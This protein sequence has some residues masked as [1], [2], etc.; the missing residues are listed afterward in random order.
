M[1]V[2]ADVQTVAVDV[3][4]LDE[5][6]DQLGLL[7]FRSVSHLFGTVCSAEFFVVAVA[8]RPIVVSWDFD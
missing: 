8:D 7:C 2:E 5:R 4:A 1:Q 6:G 3:D